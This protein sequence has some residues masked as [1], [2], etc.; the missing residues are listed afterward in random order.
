MDTCIVVV[1]WVNAT[2]SRLKS[3]TAMPWKVQRRCGN[4]EGGLVPDAATNIAV[5]TKRKMRQEKERVMVVA[6]VRIPKEEKKALKGD[7]RGSKSLK[8][9]ITEFANLCAIWDC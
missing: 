7:C 1:H 2:P 6:N 9:C 5:V 3:A 8:Q 4:N